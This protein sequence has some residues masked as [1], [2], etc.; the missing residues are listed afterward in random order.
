M[1]LSS[2]QQVNGE[3][4]CENGLSADLK[5]ISELQERQC[6]ELAA[7]E[8]V[9]LACERGARRELGAWAVTKGLR[10]RFA[11][12]HLSVKISSPWFIENTGLF[13][14]AVCSRT[15]FFEVLAKGPC[16]NG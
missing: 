16:E 11:H 1:D 14:T 13:Q 4:R 7:E 8:N 12:F 10:I 15:E 6:S 9:A 5:S 2:L 3:D